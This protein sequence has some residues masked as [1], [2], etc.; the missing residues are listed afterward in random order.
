MGVSGQRN[1]PAAL[2]P[3]ERVPFRYCL[4]GWVALRTGVD[5]KICLKW[6]SNP[7]RPSTSNGFSNK[8][9][10]WDGL[11]WLIDATDSAKIRMATERWQHD[12]FG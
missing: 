11:D 10:V 9:F 2:Y 8:Q 1:A 4:G 5:T 3:R 6:G 12:L 7:V